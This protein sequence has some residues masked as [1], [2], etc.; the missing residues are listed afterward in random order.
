M[1]EE[2]EDKIG[3]EQMTENLSTVRERSCIFVYLETSIS[4]HLFVFGS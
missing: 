4:T 2:P 1:V 3:S